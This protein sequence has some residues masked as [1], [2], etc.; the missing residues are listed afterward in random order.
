MPWIVVGVLTA[1]FWPARGFDGMVRAF[2]GVLVKAAKRG[3]DLRFDL[4]TIGP[5]TVKETLA[6]HLSGV[7]IV[8]GNAIVAEPQA[9]IAAADKASLF[10]E[11]LAP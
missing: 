7:A 10:I 6:A 11:G 8:A 9:M 2:A 5:D 4:P 3:Q 1:I